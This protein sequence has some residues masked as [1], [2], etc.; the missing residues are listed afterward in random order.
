[1]IPNNF[2]K[3]LMKNIR[4]IDLTPQN[5][6]DYG[7][8]GY[9]N[10]KKHIELKRKID[11]FRD[12]KPKGLT[13]KAAI[14][15]DKSYQGMIEYIPGKYAFRPVSA[16]D[17][18]FIHCIFVGFKKEYKNQGIGSAM[19]DEVINDAESQNMNGVAVVTRKGSFMAGK[20]IFE[21]KEF[22]LV[23]KAPPDF[24]LLVKKFDEAAENPQFNNLKENLKKYNKGM[25]I[26]RSFQ[27][28]YTEKNIK[29]MIKTAKDKYD[30]DVK[31]IELEDHKA[32]QASPCAFGV[33]CII[34]N[35]KIISHH[36]ISNTRFENILRK[37]QD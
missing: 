24:T 15:P 25:F 28:P 18:M 34:H 5:I 8:C 37:R 33:F 22:E 30:L 7:L 29:D 31:L 2:L 16:K 32:V 23:D 4:I 6:P 21:L 9:K 27:C 12:Y 17:Y 35:G 1:M 10:V 19:I 36:P 3:V 26:L 20:D 14:A 11:W 13:L